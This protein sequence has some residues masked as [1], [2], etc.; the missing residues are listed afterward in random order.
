MAHMG[1]TPSLARRQT[2][3]RRRAAQPPRGTEPSDF[4][5]SHTRAGGHVSATRSLEVDQTVRQEDMRR[6]GGTPLPRGAPSVTYP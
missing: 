2:D 3:A 4:S 5:A 6:T 1:S